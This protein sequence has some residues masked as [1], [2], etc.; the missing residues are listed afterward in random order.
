MLASRVGWM[1]GPCIS[2]PMS[3]TAPGAA[4]RR[5]SVNGEAYG[6]KGG[7]TGA[8]GEVPREGR[9]FLKLALK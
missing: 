7:I 1:A 9:G 3:L 6:I 5:R 4:R 2:R 8:G